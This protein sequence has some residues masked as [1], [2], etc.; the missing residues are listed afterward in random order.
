LM[1]FQSN[2]SPEHKR[3]TVRTV[4]GWSGNDLD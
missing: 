2:A 1:L 4:W 3:E